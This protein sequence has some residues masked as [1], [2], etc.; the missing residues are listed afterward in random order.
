M[1]FPE[2]RRQPIDQLNEV[3]IDT[4]KTLKSSI[5]C[6]GVGLHSG[7][8]VSMVLKPAEVDAGI[9]F[10]R[11]DI[12]GKGAVIRAHWKNVVDTRLCTVLGNSDGITI[13]TVEHLMAALAG[14]RIDNAE[15]EINGPEIPVMDGSAEP[16]VFLIECAGVLDQGVP[17]RGIRI[18]KP[19]VVEEGGAC[20]ALYPGK[21][22]TVGFEIKFDSA[23][24]GRQAISLGLV[25]G[26]FKKELSRA[27]TF[28]FLHEVEQLWANGFALGGS[29]DNAVV[30]SGDKI[31]NED[32]LRYDDEFVR[33]KALDA[34]G[35][36]FMAGAPI[37]GHYEGRCSGHALTNRLLEALFADPENWCEDVVTD[38]L[39]DEAV[40]G[41]TEGEAVDLAASA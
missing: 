20:A 13:G 39:E 16:F 4:Q 34:L 25:N 19:V 21:G 5:C 37:I 27:R 30:V 32:G 15:I 36:L 38:E 24:V 35:D 8:K 1:G 31:L 40:S 3:K 17:R 6:T 2:I 9:T 26:T 18:L 7:A 12:G 41:L 29:L 22:S 11:T 10:R 14:S 28:G 23:L 33:H